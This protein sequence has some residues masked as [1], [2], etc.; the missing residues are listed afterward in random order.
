MKSTINTTNLFFAIILTVVAG[1]YCYKMYME[2]N[3]LAAETPQQ[4][5]ETTYDTIEVRLYV[6]DTIRHTIV[7]FKTSIELISSIDTISA[8]A[9]SNDTWL[10]GFSKEPVLYK[11]GWFFLATGGV[12]FFFALFWA[13]IYIIYIFTDNEKIKTKADSEA[14]SFTS[15][16]AIIWAIGACFFLFNFLI[17]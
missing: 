2:G 12:S 11:M 3:K 6:L 13:A 17:N 9:E 16:A 5:I 4:V 1:F 15:V 10:D 8:K 7:D 14:G